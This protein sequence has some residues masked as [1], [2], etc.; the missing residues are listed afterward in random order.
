MRCRPLVFLPSEIDQEVKPD[1]NPE[2]WVQV[3]SFLAAKREAKASPGL[4]KGSSGWAGLLEAGG[5]RPGMARPLAAQGQEED[6]YTG[7]RPVEDGA[8]WGFSAP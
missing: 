8:E 7:K 5:R 6:A 2:H 3:N 4:G 1:S